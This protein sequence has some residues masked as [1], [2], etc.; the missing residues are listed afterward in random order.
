MLKTLH[1]LANSVIVN[2]LSNLGDLVIALGLKSNK[3]CYR[4]IGVNCSTKCSVGSN[5]CQNF[6]V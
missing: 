6:I 4:S 5:C 3:C 2:L 1:K